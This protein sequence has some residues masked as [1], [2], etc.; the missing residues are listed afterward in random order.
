[1]RSRRRYNAVEMWA[2]RLVE[3]ERGVDAG[4][5]LFAGG[6]VQAVAGD[7]VPIAGVGGAGGADAGALKG[8]G[9]AVG[10]ALF[11]R[12]L[13]VAAGVEASLGRREAVVAG[14]S[15]GVGRAAELLTA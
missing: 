11:E 6:L 4:G 8:G 7:G 14:L 3:P 1:M 12:V 15:G 10:G 5:G 2:Q 9:G 13:E